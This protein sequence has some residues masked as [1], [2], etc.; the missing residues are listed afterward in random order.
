MV[1]VTVSVDD[2]DAFARVAE[3]LREHPPEDAAVTKSE[4]T[5]QAVVLSFPGFG[6]GDG[7]PALD[8]AGEIVRG[9]SE[10]LQVPINLFSA[11][12]GLGWVRFSAP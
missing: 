11:S 12:V 9:L 7:E 1:P 5:A 3:H 2:K 8:R 4:D 10:L 6:E